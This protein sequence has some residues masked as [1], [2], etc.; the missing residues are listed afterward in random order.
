M[1]QRK[2]FDF[3]NHMNLADQYTDMP[4]INEKLAKAHKTLL[5]TWADLDTPDIF[6]Y[7]W[8]EWGGMIGEFYFVRWKMFFDFLLKEFDSKDR[9]DL[10]KEKKLDSCY[11]REAFYTNDFY[12]EPGAFELSW[13]NGK[14]ERREA[15]QNNEE[16]LSIAKEIYKIISQFA[17]AYAI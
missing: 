5:T 2:E 16:T 8:R 3:Y 13:K 14:Y 15:V 10:K 12:K 4:E 11:G 1:L 7:A 6:D 9:Y 17:I